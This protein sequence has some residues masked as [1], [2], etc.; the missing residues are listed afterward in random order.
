MSE[1]IDT[2]SR[3][4]TLKNPSVLGEGSKEKL[5]PSVV[6]VPA[7]SC[8]EVIP[9]EGIQK[10]EFHMDII[11]FSENK[12]CVFHIDL[13]RKDAIDQIES[14]SEVEQDKL[15]SRLDQINTTNDTIRDLFAEL[16][17]KNLAINGNKIELEKLKLKDGYDDCDYAA[18]YY[19]HVLKAVKANFS[20]VIQDKEEAVK[21]NKLV[22]SIKE[23]I[24]NLGECIS[25]MED[26]FNLDLYLVNPIYTEKDV[27]AS[28]SL[29][30]EKS[31]Y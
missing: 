20:D 1:S 4:D 10:K 21:I 12:L 11:G 15:K 8:Q 13:I 30:V 18:T 9:A 2:L 14:Y 6:G 19:E 29:D 25:S 27:G 28:R 22:K 16:F 31:I 23:E 3:S 24:S 7:T 5:V 17:A 26:K